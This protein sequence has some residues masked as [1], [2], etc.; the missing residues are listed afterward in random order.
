MIGICGGRVQHSRIR[1]W[2]ELSEDSTQI[3]AIAGYTKIK[4]VAVLY[5]L[6]PEHLFPAAVDDSVVVHKELLKTYKPGVQRHLRHAPPT[7]F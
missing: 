3:R 7:T 6:V 1:S 2:Q 4:V 5:R